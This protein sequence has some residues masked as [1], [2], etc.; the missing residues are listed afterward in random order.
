M[1]ILNYY[2]TDIITGKEAEFK[3]DNLNL[4][5]KGLT[6]ACLQGVLSR[7]NC[8]DYNTKGGAGFTQWDSTVR[9]L[10]EIFCNHIWDKYEHGGLEGIVSNELKI[11]IIPSSGNLA[12]GNPNQPASNKN[13]KG[14]NMIQLVE[15]SLQGSLFYGYP[16]QTDDDKFKTYILLYNSNK[17]ELKMELSEPTSIRKGKV[18]AWN[19][20]II[21]DSFKF[22]KE[23][24]N[25][26]LIDNNDTIDIPVLRKITT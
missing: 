21:I 3:L 10:R 2:T 26:P 20:R 13:P 25:I 1:A 23:P 19:E 11:R 9:A 14:M 16:N 12:T 6:Q 7:S 17:T 15:R 5:S 18:V 22:D 8:T 4:S 24:I